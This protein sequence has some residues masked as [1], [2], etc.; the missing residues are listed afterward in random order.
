MLEPFKG[1][2]VSAPKLRLSFSDDCRLLGSEDVIGGQE[3]VKQI[4]VSA[5]SN[6]SSSAGKKAGVS[7]HIPQPGRR[8]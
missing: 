1:H 8:R 5:H 7:P 4:K 3:S 2:E 6:Q